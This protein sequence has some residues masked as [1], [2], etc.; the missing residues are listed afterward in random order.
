MHTIGV[1]YLLFAGFFS[2]MALPFLYRKIPRNYFHGYRYGAAMSSPEAWYAINEYAARR[3]LRYC[4]ALSVLGAAL[5]LLS[6]FV[7]D[8]RDDEGFSWPSLVGLV[9]ALYC[10]LRP[11]WETSRWAKLHYHA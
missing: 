10:L 6:R 4:G 2:L 3:I 8:F 9:S 11:V 5:L 1:I 7:G